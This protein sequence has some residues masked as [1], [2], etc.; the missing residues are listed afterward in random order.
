MWDYYNYRKCLNDLTLVFS[1][2]HF[3]KFTSK[4]VEKRIIN[5]KYFSLFNSDFLDSQSYIT[6][7]SLIKN[8][9][10]EHNVTD[11]SHTYLE[12]EWCAMM[13]LF[14]ISKTNYNFE[15]MFTYIGLEEA[16]GMYNIY[17]EMDL[18][19]SYNRFIELYKSKSIIK[20][21]MN[22]L[23]LT[24]EE[25]SKETSISPSMI[26]ALKNR[27]R[28]IK[29]LEVEKAVKLAKYLDIQVETLLNN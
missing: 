28:N 11:F 15:T 4:T 6:S 12:L 23:G 10:P 26:D 29:K 20:M 1:V 25:I 8:I 14:I 3:Y 9:F 27:R 7:E 16:I 21:R 2:G 19:H 13:Y 18:T 5:S 22:Q 24:N 17:H